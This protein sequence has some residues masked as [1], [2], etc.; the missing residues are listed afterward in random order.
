MLVW[1][2]W[3][4]VGCDGL[5]EWLSISAVFDRRWWLLCTST[6]VY[7]SVLLLYCCVC[8]VCMN[9]IGYGK[10]NAFPSIHPCIYPWWF[11]WWTYITTIPPSLYHRH[12]ERWWWEYG[13]VVTYLPI[14]WYCFWRLA[15]VTYPNP[16]ARLIELVMWFEYSLP[17]HASMH[18]CENGESL[19]KN[20]L[21]GLTICGLMLN[22]GHTDEV[23]Q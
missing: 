7:C 19:T 16:T 22:Y 15:L 4:E 2:V 14:H 20:G 9:L 1:Y 11:F 12:Y 8:C 5:V 13:K 17:I 23:K 21:D 10:T 18:A 6:T 3:C